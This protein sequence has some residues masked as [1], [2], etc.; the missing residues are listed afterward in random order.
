MGGVAW[1]SRALS[2]VRGLAR[3]VGSRMCNW[4]FGARSTTCRSRV[5]VVPDCPDRRCAVLGDMVLE[6][7]G[8]PDIMRIRRS[9]P[10]QGTMM[11]QPLERPDVV[12]VESSNQGRT[13]TFTRQL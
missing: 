3:V 9:L 12:M 1:R 4:A 8:K 5:A 13:M 6:Q 2:N 7:R 10:R 11:H